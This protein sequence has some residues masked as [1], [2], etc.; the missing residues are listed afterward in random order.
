MK[1]LKIEDPTMKMSF[2]GPDLGAGAVQTW[3]SEQK[4][5]GSTTITQADPAKGVH[6]VLVVDGTF[7]LGGQILLEPAA[8]GT[9]VTWAVAGD[10][11]GN[12]LRHLL[13]PVFESFIGETFAKSLATLKQ[14]VEAAPANAAAPTARRATP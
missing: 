1:A 4:P 14:K 11:G 10:L 9:K 5:P 8:G 12:P 6:F 2:S 13:G 3:T 7:T